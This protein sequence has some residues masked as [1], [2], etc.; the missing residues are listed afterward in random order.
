VTLVLGGGAGGNP[1]SPA[2]LAH[3]LVLVARVGGDCGSRP[4]S[5]KAASAIATPDW[6]AAMGIVRHCPWPVTQHSESAC[7]DER[8]RRPPVRPL[9]RQFAEQGGERSKIGVA[10]PRRDLLSPG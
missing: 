8:Q 3:G 6:R 2:H 5:A 4:P 1:A 9:R 10:G 7:Q